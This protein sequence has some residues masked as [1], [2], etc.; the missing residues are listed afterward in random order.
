MF[1]NEM[2]HC[3]I[4]L[5]SGTNSVYIF[6]KKLFETNH[7]WVYFGTLGTQ[8]RRPNRKRRRKTNTAKMN[9][10]RSRAVAA[11]T[12]CRPPAAAWKRRRMRPLIASEM[13]P[14]HHQVRALSTFHLNYVGV[15]NSKPLMSF[16]LC[17][18]FQ[19]FGRNRLFERCDVHRIKPLFD[20]YNKDLKLM[21]LHRSKQELFNIL[22]VWCASIDS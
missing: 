22:N 1:Y 14:P 16:E 11:R 3:D 6:N 19:N 7:Y 5:D 21:H 13:M 8:R 9:H 10:Q 15:S 17:H 2:L 20:D 18:W 4:I 12:R